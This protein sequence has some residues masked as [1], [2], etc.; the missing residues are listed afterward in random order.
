MKVILLLLIFL[1]F[2]QPSIASYTQY[3]E[4][5]L[6]L[7]LDSLIEASPGLVAQKQE[8]I[9]Q[10]RKRFQHCRTLE[11]EFWLNKLF[12]EEYYVFKADSAMR[13]ATRN[14]QIAKQLLKTRTRTGMEA[15]YFLFTGCYRAS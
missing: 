8:K 13:Y 11:E 12:Y 7:H 14:I 15:Q 4:S 10:L 1:S 3:T 5:Q 6:L 9:K 2:Y